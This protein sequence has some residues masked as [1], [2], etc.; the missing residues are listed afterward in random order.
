MWITAAQLSPS[1]ATKLMCPKCT[2]GALQQQLENAT[3]Q[4]MADMHTKRCLF[5]KAQFLILACHH[6][7]AEMPCL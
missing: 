1:Q 4:L 5:T 3:G 2:Q 7:G 6:E